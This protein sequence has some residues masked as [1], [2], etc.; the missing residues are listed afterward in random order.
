MVKSTWKVPFIP[1]KSAIL[2]N[3]D[4]AAGIVHEGNYLGVSGMSA[5]PYMDVAIF[6]EFDF[7]N[8]L[9]DRYQT[10]QDWDEA[11][12]QTIHDLHKVILELMQDPIWGWHGETRRK[13]R[14]IVS[15][16]RDIVDLGHLLE[17]QDYEILE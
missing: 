14:S 15:S 4:P 13:N 5:R 7:I 10:S 12:E 1:D 8:T 9:A 6:E 17:A 2:F 11:F 16:P 3:A